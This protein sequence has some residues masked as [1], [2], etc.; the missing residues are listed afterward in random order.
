M[1]RL[2]KLDGTK[3]KRVCSDFPNIVLL[4]NSTTLDKIKVTIGHAS[5]GNNYFG[6][7]VTT[8]TLARSLEY[9]MV[10]SNDT[11][12]ALSRSE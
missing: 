4:T 5:I 8:F 1:M 12:Q 7:T 10:V 6:E 2:E 9:P 11:K 3:F